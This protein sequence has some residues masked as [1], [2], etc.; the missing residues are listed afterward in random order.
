ML[1]S[2]ELPACER[3]SMST[4][5]EAFPANDPLVR[6]HIRFSRLTSRIY[7]YVIGI[8]I[9]IFIVSQLCICLSIP[10]SEDAVFSFV[11]DFVRRNTWGVFEGADLRKA[12]RWS[13]AWLMINIGL[14]TCLSVVSAFLM[15]DMERKR[16]D[17]SWLGD[18]LSSAWQA[19][20][21]GPAYSCRWIGDSYFEKFIVS[22][23]GRENV[24]TR[25]LPGIV[26]KVQA[27]ML[28]SLMS[29]LAKAYIDRHTGGIS[30]T[31]TVKIRLLK[32]ACLI[33]WGIY[34]FVRAL[35]RNIDVFVEG[36]GR[37]VIRVLDYYERH[38][39]R[40]LGFLLTVLYGSP[41]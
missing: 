2:E 17:A 4:F 33:L 40:F 38:R 29:K 30:N 21:E 6:K 5:P 14:Y 25:L 7:F 18:K 26:P 13:S 36:I 35:E 15:L 27:V 9:S 12:L 37:E 11:V 31:L 10:L 8:P 3:C 20:R 41:E 22:K 16:E 32:A 1:S 39:G 34:P 24:F 23:N 19:L 28:A